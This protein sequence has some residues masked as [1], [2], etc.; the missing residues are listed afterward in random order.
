ELSV[1]A[2]GK[3]AFLI[4]NLIE[5]GALVGIHDLFRALDY[6]FNDVDRGDTE[7]ARHLVHYFDPDEFETNPAVALLLGQARNVISEL[8]LDCAK[9][10]R[11]YANFNLFGDYQFAHPDG[12][13]WTVLFFI[14]S[15]WNPDW[16]GEFLL[17][18]DGPQPIALAIAP[19]PGRMVLF[20]GKTLHRGGSPSKYC[21]DARITLAIKFC[22]P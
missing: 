14:N 5:P 8:G 22:R 11:I 2:S 3:R 4:D 15:A 9:V 18:E 12:H 7:F 13:V 16:G 20:D 10:E 1:G 6:G 21:L 17:Y 19:K